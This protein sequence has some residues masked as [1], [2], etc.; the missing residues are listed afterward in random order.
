MKIQLH[1]VGTKADLCFNL[2][3]FWTMKSFMTDCHFMISGAVHFLHSNKPLS[4]LVS[5]G[6]F[7]K[8]PDSSLNSYHKRHIIS[9]HLTKVEV[10]N[11]FWYGLIITTIIYYI[12]GRKKAI[13]T[14][15]H[16]FKMTW[17]K[18]GDIFIF[19]ISTKP[20]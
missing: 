3:H 15:R 8:V 11:V 17:H 14:N 18:K 20:F 10:T 1:V 19:V 7:G 9:D 12:K 13:T 2:R 6:T 4:K 5:N 16:L